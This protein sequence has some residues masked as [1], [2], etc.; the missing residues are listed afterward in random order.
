M[1]KMRWQVEKAFA[2][3]CRMCLQK[4]TFCAMHETTKESKCR[5]GKVESANVE[6]EKVQLKNDSIGAKKRI[7][8][9]A[10]SCTTACP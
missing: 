6:E 10:L 9:D 2:V 3:P 4:W 1:T 8:L 5:Y 7:R